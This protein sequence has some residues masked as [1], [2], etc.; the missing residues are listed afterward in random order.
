MPGKY[1][2][3][4][5]SLDRL[6][7]HLKRT[8]PSSPEVIT[9]E[10][11][12]SLIF[13]HAQLFDTNFQRVK[14]ARLVQ[15]LLK[16]YQQ[17]P[18]EQTGQFKRPE[19]ARFRPL[20]PLTIT[21]FT[22]LSLSGQES[23]QDYRSDDQFVYEQQGH[24]GV[25]HI[26]DYLNY[27]YIRLI[28]KGWSTGITPLALFTTPDG[29]IPAACLQ[30]DLEISPDNWKDVREAITGRTKVD[31]HRRFPFHLGHSLSS[32]TFIASSPTGTHFHSHIYYPCT[33]DSQL[34]IASQIGT[35]LLMNK[36]HQ[37]PIV[38]PR[39]LGHTLRS[40]PNRV[41]YGY[42]FT[43]P[44][45]PELNCLRIVASQLKPYCPYPL[46]TIS[47]RNFIH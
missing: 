32:G 14:G 41:A 45:D 21:D 40:L 29:I 22:H 6:L 7:L 25:L 42:N 24:P 30:L 10:K 28:P 43:L 1:H 44:P 17:S 26:R 8:K 15:L 11:I 5:L 19:P 27:Y 9:S 23:L 33:P 36:E 2:Q 47:S 18:H 46:A 20:S 16:E 31:S 39:Q 4:S 3:E 34:T 38:D 13:N 35:A 37:P 12:I